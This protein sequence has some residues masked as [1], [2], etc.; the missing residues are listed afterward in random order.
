MA[1]ICIG[2]S[3]SVSGGMGDMKVRLS[4]LWLFA[5]VNYL[6]CDVVTLCDPLFLR[7]LL[8]GT[9]GG[10]QFT[11]GF[12]LASA[13]LMEIPMAMILLYRVLGQGANR[14]ANIAAAAVMAAVQIASVAFGK[15]TIYYLFFSAF[16]I[17]TTLA[18]MWFAWRWKSSAG[19]SIDKQGEKR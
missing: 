11:Q 19:A 10:F 8:T 13:V 15:P 9:A 7:Q 1:D 2:A 5:L 4:T 16:E 3:G 12:L 17:A 14:W 6:Y 18:I